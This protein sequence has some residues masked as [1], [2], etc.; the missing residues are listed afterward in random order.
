MAELAL[1]LKESGPASGARRF[2]EASLVGD[3]GG[4]R[5]K[6]ASSKSCV[7]VRC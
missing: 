1:C 6:A 5:D 2:W 7:S 3:G 4:H